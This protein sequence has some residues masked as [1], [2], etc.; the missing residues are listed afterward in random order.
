MDIIYFTDKFQQIEIENDFFNEID[1]NGICYWDLVRHDVFY[2]IYNDISNLERLKQIEKKKLLGKELLKIIN[3]LWGYLIFNYKIYFNK[4]K[5]ILF[6]ASRNKTNE[7]LAI[8]LISK[9]ITNAITDSKLIIESVNENYK[10]NFFHNILDYELLLKVKIGHFF[11]NILKKKHKAYTIATILTKEFNCTLDLNAEITARIVNHKI[12]L[13]HYINLFK[14][15]KPKA[16]FV[17]QNGICKAIFETAN[18]LNIRVVELQHGYIGYV[19]AAYSYPKSIKP[20]DLNTLPSDFFSFSDFWTSKL[21]FP[22]KKILPIGNSFNSVKPLQIKKEYDLTFIFADVYTN[23]FL[24]IIE[25]LLHKGYIGTICIKL[26]PNQSQDIIPISNKF[27][28][29][30]NVIVLTN[31]YS[32]SEV[33]NKS[34]AIVG[35]QSTSLYEAIHIGGIKIYVLKRNDYRLHKDIFEFNNVF[36]IDNTDE[37]LDNQECSSYSINN[38]NMFDTFKT[39]IFN[40]FLSKL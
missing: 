28:R 31:E 4:Y 38:E 27:S 17:V 16:V 24:P 29:Y 35:I 34:K 20:G 23:V 36:L 13:K 14:K 6:I 19:H 9:D 7:G 15:T 5:Y 1:E 12:Q 21:N 32:M 18:S 33:L 26:H 10:N 22:V 40:Q 37:I 11:N 8:D 3:I 39:D 2:L 25:D 30:S